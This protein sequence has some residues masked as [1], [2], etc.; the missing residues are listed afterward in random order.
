M[1]NKYY[2]IR[3]GDFAVNG[4]KKMIYSMLSVLLCIDDYYTN[5][6]RDCF[7]IMIGSSFVWAI[8]E[9]LL[10]VTNTRI[11]KPM[12]V[13]YSSRK[14]ELPRYLGV[15]LQGMQEGGCVSTFGL[16]FGD[17]LY[18]YK[19]V[20]LYHLFLLYMVLNMSYK[21]TNDKILSKR[22]INTPSSLLL[23][24]GMTVYNGI[25]IYNHPEHMSREIS[26]YASMFYMSSIWTGVSYYKGFRKVE[27]QEYKDAQY[28]VK[29]QNYLDAFY[30][31]GYDVLFEI[32][33]AYMTF[34]NWFVL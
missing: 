4:N 20:T 16:Y 3:T 18:N 14:I 29:P 25:S 1:D 23:M 30:V 34:Y 13:S 10:H 24:G 22:Q 32:C 33:I 27:V 28:I 2:I 11:I 5:H 7:S 31:L 26:M 17:R 12:Y 9:L 6:S 21:Q 8:V 19:Y 15:C